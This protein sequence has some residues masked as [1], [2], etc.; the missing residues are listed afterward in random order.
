MNFTKID[1]VHF[2]TFDSLRFLSFLLVFLRHSPVPEDSIL[3]Y[4]SH[5]G[6]IGVSFFFVLSGFLIT[7]ILILEKINNQGKVPLKK[8][9]KRRVLRIWPLYYAM[10]IFAMCTPYILSFFN[11]SYSNE[12]YLPNWFFTLTFLEN[13]MAMFTKLLPNVAP[14]TVIWS[15]CVEEHFYIFW[16]L[17]FYFISLKNIS[18]LLIGCIIFSFIMQAV[19]ERYNLNTLD[20]FTN[21]HYFAFGAIPAYIF[22]FKKNIIEKLGEI[23]AFYKNIYAI[24]IIGFIL[25]VANTDVIPDLKVSSFLF[26]V[27]FSGLILFTLGKKNV[28]KIP[29]ASILARLGKY[30]YGLYLFH[31]IFI[32]LFVK[33][34]N[35]TNMNW[36][37]ITTLSFIGTVLLSILSYHLF[38][39]QFLK[40]KNKQP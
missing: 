34:G 6:G 30:T 15:L 13:Y 11:I 31:T 38:E 12:G 7:Y 39:K 28:F 2:H 18:K 33:I 3:Y 1:R 32:S 23:P 5:E 29:D 40:L 9:F 37:M 16:G 25:I 21:I 36:I 26:S 10:V 27:L 19:Y 14:L 35:K 4:F 22:V 17:A 24:S 20:I 8:F